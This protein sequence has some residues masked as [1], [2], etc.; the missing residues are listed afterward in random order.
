VPLAVTVD[1]LHARYVVDRPATVERLDAALSRVVD[2]LDRE[3]QGRSAAT[4]DHVCIPELALSLTLDP[5]AAVASVARTWAAE[6]AAALARALD[7]GRGTVVY[8]RT[9][10]ALVDMVVSVGRGD[11]RRAWAWRQVGLIGDRGATEVPPAAAAAALVRHPELAPAALTAAGARGEI[12]LTDE[13]WLAVAKAVRDQ[14][15]R[16][17]PEALSADTAAERRDDRSEHAA[18]RIAERLVAL[19]LVARF[20]CRD[21]ADADRSAL[22]GL[23][24]VCGAPAL[25]RSGAVVLAV[26]ERLA[27]RG[28]S[29]PPPSVPAPGATPNAGR[30][31][32]RADHRSQ[33]GPV[34]ERQS[35]PVAAVGETGSGSPTPTVTE[36]P[37]GGERSGV[38]AIAPGGRDPA[39]A[40][41][42]PPGERI[43][44]DLAGVVASEPPVAWTEWGGTL[45][46]IHALTA[47]GLP[48]EAPW[49]WAD[50]PWPWV[51]TNLAAR[52]TEAPPTDPGV[53]ALGGSGVSYWDGSQSETPNRVEPA[54]EAA[55][56]A[57][58][59]RVEGW[60]RDRLGADDGDDLGWLWRRRATIVSDP[61]WVEATFPLETVDTRVRRVGLDLDP[62]FVWWLGAVVRFRYA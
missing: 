49:P 38:A 61:G 6:I 44:E 14:S 21:L 24:V 37:V 35:R 33:S 15:A 3:L 40:T 50:R 13:G 8:P 30:P 47:L 54:D 5:R 16:P 41:A 58:A 56:A 57:R 59:D 12:P 46:L 10:D 20:P 28:G 36:A 26:A 22:A 25:A 52:L 11:G 2:E 53:V 4:A 29:V 60:V 42:G 27:A 62:G 39:A 9:L 51:A 7:E 18:A 32:P 45:F 31:R 34:P 43:V 55:L 48:D 23:A 19:P 17:V 1:R